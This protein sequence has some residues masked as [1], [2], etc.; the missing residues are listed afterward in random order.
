[1]LYYGVILEG[2]A[3]KNG[4]EKSIEPIKRVL[5]THVNLLIMFRN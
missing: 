4:R 3:D 5:L 1:M 2:T